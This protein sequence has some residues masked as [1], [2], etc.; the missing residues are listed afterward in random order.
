MNHRGD[1]VAV[2]VDSRCRH[3]IGSAG[4]GTAR[5]RSS[6]QPSCWIACARRPAAG[7]VRVVAGR[8]ASDASWTSSL[9]LRAH[10]SVTWLIARMPALKSTCARRNVARLAKNFSQAVQIVPRVGSIGATAGAPHQHMTR[11]LAYLL[12]DQHAFSSIGCTSA[13]LS[14]V[15]VVDDGGDGA[16]SIHAR[17]TVDPTSRQRNR[18]YGLS[19]LSGTS[20]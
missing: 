17:G 14:L 6:H 2:D 16:V 3:S 10:R 8:I 1:E 9:A 7:V 20:R 4:T 13:C 11:A 15:T 5:R 19:R 18:R 12:M